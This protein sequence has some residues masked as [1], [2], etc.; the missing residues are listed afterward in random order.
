MSKPVKALIR[1]HLAHR[2]R[3]VRSM[4]I[5]ELTG[6]DAVTTNRI[7]GRLLQKSIRLLVVKNSL[8]RQAFR[9]I[10]LPAAAE[11]LEGPCAIA[12]GGDSVVGTVRELLDIRRELAELL[13]VKAAL[14]EGEPFCPDRVEELSRFPTRDEALGGLVCCILAPGARLAASLVAPGGKVAAL[15][16]AI[17]EQAGEDPRRAETAEAEPACR[18]AGQNSQ[19]IN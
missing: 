3:D 5:V 7:R 4:A 6:I 12:Y 2:F 9:S 16:K 11:L 10:G 15:V 17:E 1:D 18:Q 8:A 13:T 19:D 14:L